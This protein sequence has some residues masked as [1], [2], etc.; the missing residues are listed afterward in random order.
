MYI[1]I[2]IYIFRSD[3]MSFFSLNLYKSK[4]CWT[5]T[6]EKE[7]KS[8]K[9]QVTSFIQLISSFCKCINIMLYNYIV[10]FYH[11]YS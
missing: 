1:Y 11:F 4:K 2:Y 8:T 6:R 9:S 5:D 3:K 10:Q 7:K